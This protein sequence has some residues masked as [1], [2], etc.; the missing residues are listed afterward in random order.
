VSGAPPPL[1]VVARVL[2]EPGLGLLS[3]VATVRSG[4]L[5][6]D[7][8]EL[9]ARCAGAAALVTDVTVRVD[10]ELLEACGPGLRVVANY[11]VGYDN[12]DAAACAA[13]GVVVT[14]T[15]GV[16][17]EAT[18]E[19]AVTLTLAALRRVGEAERD[20][21]EGRWAS[22]SPDGWVGRELRG[23]T[24]GVV[25]PGR[26]GGRYAELVAAFGASV[27][28][29]SRR[30]RPDLDARLGARRVALDELLASCD[31]VSLH[32]PGGAGVVIDEAAVRRMR[33]GAVLV[34]TARGSL[35]DE[36]AVARALTC[37]HL[38]AAGLDVFADEPRVSRALL[39][40]PRAI[41]L[42]HIGS[43]TREARS[44]MAELVARNVLAVL[45]G[46]E[47]PTPV[48]P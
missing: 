17:V 18:A 36:A 11:A 45:R 43:A 47:P 33:P 32:V 38:G 8:E 1:V 30:P 41:L 31:V 48:T 37:G 23:A 19:L 7:R 9:H 22:W 40:A 28:Y 16:L 25:G 10:A 44:A 14:N 46:E 12:V 21:R 24:V 29:T 2:P 15:P 3:E 26:I 35:V 6:V 20:L 34:N 13:R 39:V 42:P 4:P 5:E 27:V